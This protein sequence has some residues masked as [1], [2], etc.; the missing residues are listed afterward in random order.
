M[1]PLL[2]LGMAFIALASL[3]AANPIVLRSGQQAVPLLELFTS[4]GCSSCPPAEAWLGKLR[5]DDGLWRDFVPLAW[6][7]NY[8]DRLGWPDRFAE[9]V[10]TDRQYA[11]AGPGDRVASTR[12]A[13]CA[14]D[15]SGDRAK[16]RRAGALK[17]WGN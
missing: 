16:G 5:H 12:R 2:F 13:L 11:Y 10:Y 9:R 8:W 1:R 15:A 4:E 3:P 7:V 14:R 6:H 17:S